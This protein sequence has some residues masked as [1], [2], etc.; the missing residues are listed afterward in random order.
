MY[1]IKVYNSCNT[2]QPIIIDNWILKNKTKLKSCW[3]ILLQHDVNM[4]KGLFSGGFLPPPYP[5]GSENSMVFRGCWLLSRPLERK[6]HTSPP[7][8]NSW[9]HAPE[10]QLS[11]SPNSSWFTWNRKQRF[12]LQIAIL[13]FIMFIKANSFTLWFYSML[14]L[15]PSLQICRMTSRPRKTV[16]VPLATSP[17]LRHFVS[18]PRI[19]IFAW[20]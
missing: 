3:N 15:P 9:I 7:W 11:L 8:T 6:F 19:F 17:S 12:R 18:T 20:W 14:K 13:G 4:A 16:S 10:W 2:L 1:L 5:T